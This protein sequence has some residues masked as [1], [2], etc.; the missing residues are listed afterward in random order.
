MLKTI[1]HNKFF[2][3]NQIGIA[4]LLYPILGVVVVAVIAGAGFYVYQQNKSGAG[5][6]TI[7]VFV[8]QVAQSNKSAACDAKSLVVVAQ[9]YRKGAASKDIR[10][11]PGRLQGSCKKFGGT[12][13][14]SGY[15]SI[16][17]YSIDVNNA[18]LKKYNNGGM[19][20]V[21]NMHKPTEAEGSISAF[22]EPAGSD[23]ASGISVT[24]PLGNSDP[25]SKRYCV[26][27][28]DS[29]SRPLKRDYTFNLKL[30]KPKTINNQGNITECAAS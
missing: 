14:L 1:K 12:N 13:S 19:Y 20:L 4:H 25:N 28:S 11:K 27:F 21:Y 10:A 22:I 8:K 29:P 15:S 3:L 2:R 24:L 16:F 23:I 30:T 26:A 7:T 6:S 9:L 5:K 17:K 18:T